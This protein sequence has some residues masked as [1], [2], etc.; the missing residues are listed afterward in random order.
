MRFFGGVAAAAAAMAAAGG[1]AVGAAAQAEEKFEF[2]AEVSRLMDIIVNSLYSKKEVFLREVI[3]NAADA[4]D[5]VR[6]LGIEEPLLLEANPDLEIRISFD[7][8]ERTLTIRDSGIGMTREDLINN[9][10]TVARSG[11]TAFVESMASGGDLSLIGQF[12][13]GFYSVYLVSDKVQVTSQ[14]YGE[15]QYVWTSTADS[16]YTVAKDEQGNTLGRGTEIK[17]FL[18]ED[19]LEYANQDRLEA[20]VQRYSEFITF[21]IY[22]QKTTTK[23]VD[24]EEEDDDEDL[25][26]GE[27]ED[28]DD[29]GEEDED[30]DEFTTE[31]EEDEDEEPKQKEVTTTAWER[32][33]NQPAI[34]ARAKEDISKEEYIEFYKSFSKDYTEPLTW[35]HFKAEGEVEFKSIIYVPGQAPVGMLENYYNTKA[36]LKLYVR[37]VLITDEF[38]E[39]IPKYLNFLKGVVDSDDLPLNVSRETLQQHK[40]L[41]VMGKKLVRKVLEMLRKMS[42]AEQA[43]RKSKENEDEDEDDEEDEDEEETGLSS[44]DYAKFWKAF[45]KN[46]KLGVIEDQPN[47]NRL[48]KLLRFSSTK[49]GDEL[50]SLDEYLA[51]MPE[52]Q[53]SIY[54]IAGSDRASIE[55]SPFLERAT[56]KGIEV[57]LFDDPIDEYCIQQVPEYETYKLQSLTKEGLKFGDESD[58]DAKRDQL[59]KDQFK[60]LSEWWKNTLSNKL[61]KVV[62]SNRVTNSPAILV[63]GQFGHSANMEKIMKHQAFGSGRNMMMASKKIMEINPRHPIIDQLNKLVQENEEDQEAVDLANLVFDTAL[64]NSGFDMEE[65]REFA[66]RM[67]R[68]MQT[69]LKLDS[70]DLLPEIDVPETDDA[71]ETEEAEEK[72][73]L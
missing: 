21:P 59:Y 18:K 38:D 5:K 31:D 45:G 2:Q 68:L 22:L 66:T 47:R 33:N 67:Y 29:E 71:E 10:G 58:L 25:V 4:L 35:T 9:L 27:E 49:S 12:G 36:A 43:K 60:T 1:G 7:E 73:E 20:L 50:I 3:S 69:G 24:V 48:V 16:T 70:L 23:M 56:A 19:A 42:E 55:N 11:T 57:L 40:I 61:E 14:A 39:L 62:V 26:D 15:D 44:G 41:K 30:D 32:V 72:T 52:W 51:N 28:D 6:Y 37:K 54:Y 53:K 63:T 65:P 17:L 34:W 64:L 8:E 46:I 13:V